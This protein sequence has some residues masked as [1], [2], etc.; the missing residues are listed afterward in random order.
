M[1]CAPEQWKEITQTA[2][3]G[4]EIRPT[5][6]DLWAGVTIACAARAQRCAGGSQ[7]LQL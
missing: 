1:G 3:T 7:R 4:H 6:T 2:V 5:L